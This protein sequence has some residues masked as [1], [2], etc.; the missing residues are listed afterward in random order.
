[1]SIVSRM[2]LLGK[3][4]LALSV[5]AS[6][7]AQETTGQLVGSVKDPKNAPLAGAHI[8][9]RAAQLIQPRTVVTDAQG[10]FRAPLLPPG[11]YSVTVTKDGFAG[12][13]ATNLR[14]SVGANIRQDFTL[15]PVTTASAVVEVVASAGSV[16]KTDTKTSTTLSAE[17]LNTLPTIGGDRSFAGA[18]DL[19]PGLAVNSGGGTSIRGGK[20]Q[21]TG[22]TL[23][24]VSIKD[25]YEG[26]QNTT[27][28]ID[29]AVEDTQ[30]IQSPLH[31]RFGR[32][33]SGYVNVVTK[34]GGN[35]F[36][37]SIRKYMSRD[38]WQ[39]VRPHDTGERS[40]VSSNRQIDIFLSGPVVKDRLWFAVSTIQVPASGS[41]G[42][43]LAGEDPT[44]W[45]PATLTG[46]GMEA[47]DLTFQP[48][49]AFTWDLGKKY[50]VGIT[51]DFVDAKFTFALNQDHTFDFGFS[52]N[53]LVITNRNPYGV[54]IVATLGSNSLSQVQ[55]EK[56][57][58]YGYRGTLNSSTFI[59]AR[60]SKALSESTFPSPALD[61]VR[62]GYGNIGVIFPYGFNIAPKP[63]AR[64][65][66]SGEFN[67]KKF[68]EVAGSHELD[69]GFQVFES[70]RGT[71]TQNG[72]KNHR[73][74]VPW[75]T[76]D[77]AVLS[78][79]NVTGLDPYGS[80]VGFQAVNWDWMRANF[81]TDQSATGVFGQA[82]VYTKFFGRDGVT[83]NRTTSFYVNDSWTFNSH[84]NGMLGLRIDRS[85]LTDTD[86][87]VILDKQG[88]IS[89]RFQLRYDVDGTNKHLF[90]VTGAKYIEDISAGFSDAF[91]KKG[92]STFARY[93]YSGVA[94]A[95]GTARYVDY[96]TITNPAN[97]G[98]NLTT[99]F[100]FSDVSKNAIKGDISNPYVI[101][102]TL[103]YKRAYTNG[104]YVS[105]TAVKRDWKNDFLVS[106]DYDPSY[107]VLVPDPTGSGLLP[108]T[109]QAT[110]YGNS[111]LLK[112]RYNSGELEWKQIISST[113]LFGGNYTYSRLTGNNNG[114]DQGAQA[115]RDNAATGEGFYRNALL[116]TGKL[117]TN[118]ASDGALLSDQTHKAR[119]YLTA[120]LP[121]GKGKISYSFLLRYDSGNN[122][123]AVS[124][125][126]SNILNAGAPVP[127]APTA[128]ARFYTERGALH[129]N[130]SYQV[131]SKI[132]WSLPLKGKLQLMGYVQ[133]S[134]LFNHQ[135]Q[136]GYGSGFT[137][138]TSLTNNIRVQSPARFGTDSGVPTNYILG[139]NVL[140]TLGLKF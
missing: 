140:V 90:T 128:Y 111:G 118:F 78:F 106:Q 77:A 125:N 20:T 87:T 93:G 79:Y 69:A 132:D 112:R 36:S 60:Y 23:N 126:P 30:V 38:D 45:S 68:F 54:P 5:G 101:E 65:N 46:N 89:P 43:I 44:V 57:Y 64:N 107:W 19:A 123:N 61:H 2:R 74:N 135:I 127:N 51:Q 27:R 91:I 53:K 42:E 138:A 6:L 124:S 11:D 73:F 52:Q 120:N 75:A 81:P 25:E 105:I 31:A 110:K 119:V 122:F 34:S 109:S 13:M 115:F 67:V 88:P 136:T 96:A 94:N 3:V 49:S 22:Y 84:W 83:K 95:A 80:R 58:T 24:G 48:G 86:K 63:D 70:L 41:T 40:N 56:L 129:F 71:Q 16:D 39:A 12:S 97:Y 15:K 108:R 133:V 35:D 82:A 4:A 14:I 7:C 114:G 103:G 37:G 98:N 113:W 26:R 8:L 1:M 117:E 139:R 17:T 32:T 121:M 59:E 18:A 85:K 100:A 104:S 62:F 50:L 33:G 116:A 92:N 102:F 134:N 72:A 66:Q 29:D 47:Y 10:S 9:I 130:D 99:P 55:L 21:T 131:D 28:L 76:G 137:A